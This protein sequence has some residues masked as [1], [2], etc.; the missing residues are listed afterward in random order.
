[1]SKP[2]KPKTETAVRTTISLPMKLYTDAVGRQHERGHNSFSAYLQAL[3]Y[4][5]R[6]RAAEPAKEAA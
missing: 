3:V 5:D 1:M 2:R 6:T 4:C